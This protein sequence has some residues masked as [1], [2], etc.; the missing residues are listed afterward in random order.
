MTDKLDLFKDTIPAVDA[1]MKDLWEAI[2]EEQRKNLKK[3]F[4]ILNR[5]ISSPV[6]KDPDIQEHYLEIV[7]E[8]FNKHWNSLQKH[9][10]LLW[11]LLCMCS[12]P[13]KRLHRK[14]Y[15]KLVRKIEGS[16]KKEKFLLN[17]YPNAKFDEI[18]LLSKIMTDEQ[19]KQ[20]A[21]DMGYDDKQIKELL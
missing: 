8:L 12:H 15:I 11:Q 19:V 20:M 17:Y 5:W 3:D 7:N 14:E 2:D 13:S 6:S 16:N 9:P 10:K 21:I 18:E 1:G 4:F